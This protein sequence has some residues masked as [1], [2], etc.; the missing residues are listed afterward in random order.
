[1]QTYLSDS[2]LHTPNLKNLGSIYRFVKD[3]TD[4]A[5]IGEPCIFDL[6]CLLFLNFY[7]VDLYFKKF[8]IR[9]VW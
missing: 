6:I 9:I 8:K 1:M 7:Y 4:C 2:K 5:W 3:N